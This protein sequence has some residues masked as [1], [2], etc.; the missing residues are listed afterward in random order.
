MNARD[1]GR[2]RRVRVKRPRTPVVKKKSCSFAIPR[3]VASF[4]V[5][6]AQFAAVSWR[7]RGTA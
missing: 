2:P 3:A 4:V 1:H 7:I 5:A 6:L